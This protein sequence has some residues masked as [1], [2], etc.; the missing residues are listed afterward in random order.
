MNYL[1]F[2]KERLRMVVLV[3]VLAVAALA[4]AYGQDDEPDN[5]D[6]EVPAEPAADVARERP[7]LSTGLGDKAIAQAYPD[8][9]AWL[10]LEGEDRALALFEPETRNPANGAVLILADEGQSAASGVAAALRRPFTAKGWAAMSLGLEA[11]PYALHQARKGEAPGAGAPEADGEND[12]GDEASEEDASIMIDVMDEGD[13]GDLAER[14]QTRVQATLAAGLA[15]LRE[16]G[17]DSIV[18]AGVG[19][20]ATHVTR[21]AVE[22]G[23]VAGMV[24]I[25]PVFEPGEEEALPE[26]LANKGQWPLL[27]LHSSRIDRQGTPSTPRERAVAFKRANIEGY[28]HQPVAMPE[29]PEPRDARVL[30]NRMAAWLED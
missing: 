4:P 8:A 30:V 10:E 12:E 22:S 20:A 5:P 15:D 16:R 17:Y 9:V 28:Q 29:R 19:R 26:L 14:Y 25:A 6:K 1:L 7:F 3:L 11:P 24:W 21:Q 23:D 27:E 18:L 2:K 13:L